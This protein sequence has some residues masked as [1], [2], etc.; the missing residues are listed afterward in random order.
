MFDKLL[1]IFRIIIEYLVFKVNVL[2]YVKY[3]VNCFLRILLDQNGSNLLVY[4][5]YSF[6]LFL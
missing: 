6:L 2:K 5:W 1:C 4:I 3:K